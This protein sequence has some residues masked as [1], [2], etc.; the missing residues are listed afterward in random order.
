MVKIADGKKLLTQATAF[1][2]I[3]QREKLW[4]KTL[5]SKI[6]P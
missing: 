6:P 3:D 1:F 4:G 5:F 2:S